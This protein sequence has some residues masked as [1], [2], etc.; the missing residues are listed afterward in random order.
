MVSVFNYLPEEFR[1]SSEESPAKELLV[2][3]KQWG[4]FPVEPEPVAVKRSVKKIITTNTGSKGLLIPVG[5]R[6]EPGFEMFLNGWLSSAETRFTI[7]H[8][9]G[10]T[11]FYRVRLYRFSKAHCPQRFETY[12]RAF[13]R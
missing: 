8:E 2:E 6:K 11:F 13:L 9:I 1:S 7:A 3:T 10:H 12:R 5:G 4:V